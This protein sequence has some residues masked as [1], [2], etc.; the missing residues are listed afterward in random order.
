V[1][2]ALYEGVVRHA[3]TAPSR[4]A[5]EM[6]LFLAYL[7]L[8]EL[9]EVFDGRWLWSTTRA[10]PARFS[11]ED[12]L[13]DPA[14]PLDRSVRQRVARELGWCPQG[15]IRLLTHLRYFGYVFNPISLYYCFDET[16]TRV[17]AMLA[18]V[19]NTPWKERHSYVLA[20]EP[21]HAVAP[22]TLTTAKAFHVSPFMGMDQSYRWTLSAPGDQL[23]LGIVSREDGPRPIFHAELDLARREITGR[24]LSRMLVRYPVMTAQV[25]AAVYWQALRLKRK[26]VPE[27][28]YPETAR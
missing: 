25:I 2:S 17:E 28:P 11:R 15:P 18:D 19:T 20:A 23:R 9:D 3:R 5:F 4:H 26:N 8:A 22:G 10:A 27:H 16:G 6:K 7:D 12:H 21:G 1:Q 13:G 24:N 14:L